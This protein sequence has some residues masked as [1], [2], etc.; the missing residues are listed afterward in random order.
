[1]YAFAIPSGRMEI[2]TVGNC[3]N[4]FLPLLE[5]IDIVGIRKC[6]TSKLLQL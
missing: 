3:H 6:L 4:L 5:E 2:V 1:M